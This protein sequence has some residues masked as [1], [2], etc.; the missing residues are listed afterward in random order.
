MNDLNASHDPSLETGAPEPQRQ[1]HI[2]PI[3]K[4]VF[5]YAAHSSPC[6]APY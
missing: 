5:P 6:V 4:E 1:I 3:E 2:L